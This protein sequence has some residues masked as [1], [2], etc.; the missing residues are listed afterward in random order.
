MSLLLRNKKLLTSNFNLV[1]K[2]LF[3][4]SMH[5]D[6]PDT[7]EV[8]VKLKRKKQLEKDVKKLL[9]KNLEDISLFPKSSIII[10]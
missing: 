10:T 3:S 7:I 2:R 5:I 8:E 9:N 4:Q 1:Q 6:L